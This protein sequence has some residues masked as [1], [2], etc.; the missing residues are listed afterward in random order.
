MYHK[1]FYYICLS[2]SGGNYPMDT[3]SFFA[4]KKESAIEAFFI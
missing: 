1:L 4:H 2:A 3:S